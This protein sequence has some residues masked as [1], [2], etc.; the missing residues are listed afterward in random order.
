MKLL[1]ERSLKKT[2][3]RIKT[4]NWLN[5]MNNLFNSYKGDHL[6]MFKKLIRMN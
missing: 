4:G 1:P 5:E 6:V 3:K 2:A